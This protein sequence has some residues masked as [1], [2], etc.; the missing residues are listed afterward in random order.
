MCRNLTFLSPYT[1]PLVTVKWNTSSIYTEN[2][3]RYASTFK[4]EYLVNLPVC[5]LF[6]LFV[7][8]SWCSQIALCHFHSVERNFST[9]YLRTGL[10]TDHVK[11]FTWYRI[12]L[13]VL[14]LQHLK[15][16]PLPYGLYGRWWKIHCQIVFP[17]MV[18]WHFSLTAFLSLVL[19]SLTTMCLSMDF[20]EFIFS[21]F[22]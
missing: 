19:R 2:I 8:P 15:N 20:F 9:Y 6:P 12:E 4:H 17:L 14:F 13:T 22:H 16:M 3:K 7:L 11:V 5:F 10:L 21:G 18:K 1:L